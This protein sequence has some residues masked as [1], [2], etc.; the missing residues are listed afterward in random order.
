M[1]QTLLTVEAVAVVVPE[2]LVVMD[3][4]QLAV[5]VV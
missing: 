2:E 1:E 3:L 4:A 5:M